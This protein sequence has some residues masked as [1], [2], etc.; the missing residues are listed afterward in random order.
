FR[1]AMVKLDQNLLNGDVRRAQHVWYDV[2]LRLFNIQF[3]DVNRAVPQLPHDSGKSLDWQGNSFLL[4][5]RIM[6][7]AVRYECRIYR[8]IK[9]EHAV[10]H[11]NAVLKRLEGGRNFLLLQPCDG[12]RGRVKRED[13]GI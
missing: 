7:Y 1:E 4:H 12:L 5:V 9:C 2:V 10:L 3:Q 11:A 13:A 8:R 6:V